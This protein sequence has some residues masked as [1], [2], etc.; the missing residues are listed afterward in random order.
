MFLQNKKTVSKGFG[1]TGLTLVELLTVIAIISILTGITYT[2]ISYVREKSRTTAAMNLMESMRS[3][4]VACIA[5]GEALSSRVENQPMCG[6]NS[7]RWP[8]LPNG[9]VYDNP[10][11]QASDVTA[12]NFTFSASGDGVTVTCTQEVCTTS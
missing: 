6:T 5:R 1:Q 3:T 9:W 12:R 7:L 2:G 4:A 8:H 10:N 11:A